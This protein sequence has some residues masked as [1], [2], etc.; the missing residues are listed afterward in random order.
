MRD[1]QVAAA[2]RHGHGGRL[3]NRRRL[4]TVVAFGFVVL[5]WRRTD[6]LLDPKIW[7]EDGTVFLNDAYRRPFTSVFHSYFGYLDVLPRLWALITTMFPVRLLALSYTLFA[8]TSTVL[9]YSI[10]LSSRLRW[11]IPSEGVRVLAFAGLVLLPGTSEVHANLTNAHWAMGVGLV[12][13]GLA[14]APSGRGQQ[15][16][17]RVAVVGLALSGATSLIV[18]P[19]FWARWLRERSTHNRGLAWLVTGCAALQGGFILFDGRP[20][21]GLSL[22]HAHSAAPAIFVRL[23]GTVGAGE[24][25]LAEVL[26]S[27]GV[28]G[29]LW[30]TSAT[31]LLCVVVCLRAL[32]P[33]ASFPLCAVL[34]F[35]CVALTWA[36]GG[37]LRRYDEGTAGG[38]YLVIPLAM[39]VVIC[40]AAVPRLLSRQHAMAV[41]PG[42]L[43]VILLM[44]GICRDAAL[45]PLPSIDWARSAACIADHRPCHVPLNPQGW[46]VDL[47]PLRRAY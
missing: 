13:L 36:L 5:S 21:A 31:V 4:F 22:G 47:P 40:A 16:T 45:R 23:G 6:A 26:G 32:P 35:S 46:S 12:L 28:P 18:W 27:S 15:R 41:V 9:S 3:F 19:V 39:I 34:L 24:N 38:R 17:E 11:L 37:D 10:V 25:M 30:V 33:Q 2:E 1:H 29:W 44:I 7:A 42:A 8:L 43:I 20:G 14:T